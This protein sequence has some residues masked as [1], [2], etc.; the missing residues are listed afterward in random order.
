MGGL[1]AP[2]LEG[3]EAKNRPRRSGSGGHEQAGSFLRAIHH[4]RLFTSLW[5]LSE[6]KSW[7]HPRKLPLSLVRFVLILLVVHEATR[8]GKR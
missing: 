7:S 5:F 8:F 6:R 2:L 3:E 4:L 1:I